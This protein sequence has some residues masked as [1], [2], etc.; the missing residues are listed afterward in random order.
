MLPACKMYASI[1]RVSGPVP[2][3]RQRAQQRSRS[4]GSTVAVR[5]RLLGTHI[6]N[7]A[8]MATTSGILHP[9]SRYCGRNRD[10]RPTARHRDIP[11]ALLEQLHSTSV[12]K[13]GSRLPD[14]RDLGQL[15][16]RLLEFRLPHARPPRM[17][18]R[19][20]RAGRT[21]AQTCRTAPGPAD[22]LQLD[23]PLQLRLLRQRG[24][25][26]RL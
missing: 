6:T 15:V 8:A 11:I 24:I 17:R 18:A 13:R 22:L 2:Q 5:R 26:A 20:G 16:D 14:A 3:Q 25:Q 10:R 4:I 19:S 1:V 7:H 9:H 23:I 12:V 21:H